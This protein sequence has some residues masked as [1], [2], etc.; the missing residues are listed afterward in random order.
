[1]FSRKTKAVVRKWEIRVY[2]SQVGVN[3]NDEKI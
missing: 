1:M 2:V 3:L